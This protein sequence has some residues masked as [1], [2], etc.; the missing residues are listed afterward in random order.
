MPVITIRTDQRAYLERVSREASKKAGRRV[1]P[2]EVAQQILDICIQ[3]EAIYEA[4]TANPVQPDRRE[5]YK[6]AAKRRS[7]SL[8]LGELLKNVT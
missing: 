4:R 7:T 3:D 1:S 2:T 5:I 6:E 8:E